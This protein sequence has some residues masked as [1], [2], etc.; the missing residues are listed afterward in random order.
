[1]PNFPSFEFPFLNLYTDDIVIL[2]LL[3]VLYKED[4]KDDMLFICLL[5]LLIN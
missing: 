3:F 4:V 2:C 1:M 5:L